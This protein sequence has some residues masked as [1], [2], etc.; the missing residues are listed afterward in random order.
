LETEGQRYED[1]TF[2]ADGI[3]LRD[4]DVLIKSIQRKNCPIY[5]DSQKAGQELGN[6]YY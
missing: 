1:H 6:S 5:L 4:L 2:L 3:N